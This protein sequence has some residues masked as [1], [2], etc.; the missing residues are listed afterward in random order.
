MDPTAKLPHDERPVLPLV[1]EILSVLLHSDPLQRIPST[2]LVKRLEKDMPTAVHT[3][4]SGPIVT[5]E[6]IVLPGLGATVQPLKPDTRSE[7]SV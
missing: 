5:E 3:V 7:E 1:Q 2:E 6:H 4:N